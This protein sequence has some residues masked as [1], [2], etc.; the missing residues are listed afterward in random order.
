MLEKIEMSALP[1]T[2]DINHYALPE[3]DTWG[4]G[5]G[6]G[7]REGGREGEGWRKGVREGERVVGMEAMRV[8]ERKW[9]KGGWR[10]GASRKR[11][12]GK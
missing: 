10:E 1:S 12:N 6:G 3:R 11:V 5:G 9:G 7:G 8:G 2:E 4:G